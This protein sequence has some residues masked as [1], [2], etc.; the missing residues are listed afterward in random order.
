[1]KVNPLFILLLF[2][3]VTFTSCSD[4]DDNSNIVPPIT[5]GSSVTVNNTFQATAFGIN[6]ETDFAV[7]SGM[8]AGDFAA[9]ATV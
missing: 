8:N 5:L 6:D 2:C 4:D 9:N 1:M 7:I 3:S